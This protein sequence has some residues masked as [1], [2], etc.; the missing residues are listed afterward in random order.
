MGSAIDHPK[1]AKARSTGRRNPTSGRVVAI[2][3]IEPAS[4]KAEKT[5]SYR[6][7]LV[8][9]GLLSD[10]GFDIR[11]DADQTRQLFQILT[12][13]QTWRD[14]LHLGIDQP[15]D[16]VKPL[17]NARLP[18][19]GEP[20]LVRFQRRPWHA[21]Q[22]FVVRASAI[23]WQGT[24]EQLASWVTDPDFCAQ[25]GTHYAYNNHAPSPGEYPSTPSSEGQQATVELITGTDY[26]VTIRLQDPV[27]PDIWHI[28]DPIVK[29][30]SGSGTR[31][32]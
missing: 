9:D 26:E 8:F 12:A 5:S 23:V 16:V 13:G 25:R 24:E 3:G 15:N 27:Q 18:V 29:T 30:G 1:P 31:P 11:I 2:H 21:E 19:P 22:P 6:R 4:A 14:L 17:H 32:Q 28:L 20:F 7:R 10:G